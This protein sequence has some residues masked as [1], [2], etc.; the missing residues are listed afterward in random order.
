MMYYLKAVIGARQANTDLI[1]NSLRAAIAKNA[2]L[3]GDAKTDME[4]FK[5]FNDDS[6]KSV[7]K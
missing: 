3:A 4:F 7:V 2:K 1:Y 6:F 5:Y